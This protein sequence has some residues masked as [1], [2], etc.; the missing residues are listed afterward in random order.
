MQRTN[1]GVYKG[2]VLP[3]VL[4]QIIFPRSDFVKRIS[5]RQQMYLLHY[6][7][8]LSGRRMRIRHE[9][10]YNNDNNKILYSY[11]LYINTFNSAVVNVSFLSYP[12]FCKH[13]H[14]MCVYN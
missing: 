5:E 3:I 7:Y 6:K 9:Q 14:T 10:V 13:A 2:A 11:K 1:S 12:S 4:Q 8:R